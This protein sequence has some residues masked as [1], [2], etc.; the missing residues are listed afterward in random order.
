MIAQLELANSWSMVDRGP[1]I[2]IYYML[3]VSRIRVFIIWYGNNQLCTYAY[4]KQRI[5][6]KYCTSTALQLYCTCVDTTVFPMNPYSKLLSHVPL[7]TLYRIPLGFSICIPPTSNHCD[8]TPM[9]YTI[10]PH[11]KN[12]NVNRSCKTPHLPLITI[13][14]VLCPF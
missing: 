12:I 7:R 13:Q 9:G 4:P 10:G 5:F 1:Y 2:R 11:K 3:F 14:Y 8:R 6:V